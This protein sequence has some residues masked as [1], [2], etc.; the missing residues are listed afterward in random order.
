MNGPPPDVPENVLGSFEFSDAG[1]RA[2]FHGHWQAH[3]VL[4]VAPR[5]VPK[6]MAASAAIGVGSCCSAGYLESLCRNNAAWKRVDHGED[7]NVAKV[8]MNNG[9]H[10][11]RIMLPSSPNVIDLMQQEEEKLKASVKS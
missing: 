2:G 5:S 3:A 1:A 7:H 4:L 6:L 10:S 8:E 11:D 9:I